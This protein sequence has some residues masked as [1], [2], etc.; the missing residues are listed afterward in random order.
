MIYW[1]KVRELWVLYERVLRHFSVFP[2]I[3][4]PILPHK[5]Q[6]IT[7]C[8]QCDYK[9]KT[10]LKHRTHYAIFQNRRIYVSCQLYGLGHYAACVFLPIYKWLAVC[11]CWVGIAYQAVYAFLACMGVESAR[12]WACLTVLCICKCRCKIY[13]CVINVCVYYNCMGVCVRAFRRV[14]DCAL[15]SRRR[16]MKQRGD[17]S[18]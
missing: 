10:K 14:Y 13:L 5:L 2:R 3:H 8:F 11:A 18:E 9:T 12:A 6:K 15:L 7:K 16:L 1:V 17:R 4:A